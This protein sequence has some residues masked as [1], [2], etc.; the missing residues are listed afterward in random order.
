MIK[1]HKN[2]TCQ[3]VDMAVSSEVKT[4]KKLSKYKDLEID[5]ARMWKMQ[6]ETVPVVIGALG[7]IK[8]G[9]DKYVKRIRRLLFKK[10]PTF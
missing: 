3:I 10:Q 2:C 7:V 8:K 6:T 9:M 1:D 5:I 4:A